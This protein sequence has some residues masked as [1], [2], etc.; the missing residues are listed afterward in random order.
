MS[1]VET[2]LFPVEMEIK[3]D[4]LQ[5]KINKLLKLDKHN[6]AKLNERLGSVEINIDYPQDGE[7]GP[8][9]SRWKSK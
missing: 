1:G 7:R 2:A 8:N 9:V 4:K 3:H 5:S 6:K